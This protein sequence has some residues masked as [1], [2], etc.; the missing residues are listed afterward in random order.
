M[1]I[2]FDWS[3]VIKDAAAAH[4]WV[5][6][7]MFEKFGLK[8]I[9]LE[10]LKENWVQP[11]M[12]FYNKYLPNLTLEEE[13]TAYREA[14]LHEDCPKSTAFPGIPELVKKLKK[15][16]DYVAVISSD[17]PET[18]LPEMKE[19]GLENIFDDVVIHTH[20]KTEAIKNLINVHSME[21]AV[22]FFIGDSNH[23]IIAGKRAR[24]KTIAVTWGFSTERGLKSENPDFLVHD[25]K[26]LEEVIT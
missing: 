16:G 12:L 21:P 14:I 8:E 3:G 5:V 24:V 6:N 20:D 4:L 17:L 7:R 10:E 1:N 13:Q 25:I 15:R 19:Y 18:V 23:E 22:T 9:T 2:I 26:E 11:Y